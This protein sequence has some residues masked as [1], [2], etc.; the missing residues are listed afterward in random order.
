MI[1]RGLVVAAM[2]LLAAMPGEA[3][4]RQTAPARANALVRV[5]ALDGDV[6]I[7]GESRGDVEVIELDRDRR[8]GVRVSGGGDEVRI[9][10]ER[11]RDI[12]VRVPAGARIQARTR[13]GDLVI[14]GVTGSIAAEA[15][16]GDIVVDGSPSTVTAETLSGD[17]RVLGEVRTVRIATVSGDITIPRAVG[18]IDATTTSGDVEITSRG[19]RSGSFESTSGDV[20]F[21]GELLPDALV[22][23]SSSSGD[24]VINVASNVSADFDLESVT[25]DVRSDLGPQPQRNRY[26]GGASSRFTAGDGGARVIVRNVSGDTRLRTR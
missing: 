19:V 5:Q 10:A 22:R 15:M 13:N 1:E 6:R 25:G 12:E 23:I 20:V 17:I 3:Q 18:T 9:E 8:N 16:V 14:S 2:A 11:N 24:I 26:T 7:R 21:D 4:N